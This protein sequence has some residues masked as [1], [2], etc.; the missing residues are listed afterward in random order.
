MST[1]VI[2][3]K[4][5]Q[6]RTDV[7]TRGIETENGYPLLKPCTMIGI[8]YID[9]ND[10]DLDIGDV[11]VTP[12]NKLYEVEDGCFL[13]IL[14]QKPDGEF[15]LDETVGVD[16]EVYP[17]HKKLLFFENGYPNYLYYTKIYTKKYAR[18]K[19]QFSYDDPEKGVIS[20]VK[21]SNGVYVGTIKW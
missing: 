20:A 3:K 4:T 7:F 9:D 10:N 17:T 19:K 6:K 14:R 2:S 18:N 5:S 11:Y 16:D 8:Q 15:Y 1:V 12:N 13:G 21:E